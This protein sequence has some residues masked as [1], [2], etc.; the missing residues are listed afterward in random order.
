LTAGPLLPFAP[1]LCRNVAT[2]PDAHICR[3]ALRHEVAVR[4]EALVTEGGAR[5]SRLVVA[6]TG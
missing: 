1:P 4:R 2:W 3:D 6:A 5:P